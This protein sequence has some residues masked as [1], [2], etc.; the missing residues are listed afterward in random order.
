M[1]LQKKIKYALVGSVAFLAV[2][3]FAAAVP[4]SDDFYFQPEWTRSV[5]S[6]PPIG[7]S[8]AN[9]GNLRAFM[10]GNDFGFFSPDGDVFRGNSGGMRFSAGGDAWCVYAEDA[11]NTEVYGTD[12]SRKMTVSGAGFVRITENGTYLFH[13]GGGAVS[14]YADDGALIW[15]RD[16]AAPITAFSD[17]AAGT[18]IGYGNGLLLAVD[19]EGR[20]LFSFYPGGS[21]YQVVLG[22]ALSESGAFAVCV[23]GVSP[24]RVILIEIENRQHRITAH[25][26]LEGELRRQAFAGFSESGNRAFFETAAGLGIIDTQARSFS[27]VAVEGRIVSVAEYPGTGFFAVLANTRPGSHLLSLVQNPGVKTAA[28]SFDCQDAF[29]LFADGGLCLGADGSISKISLRTAK[30]RSR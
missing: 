23:S 28:L 3:L 1:T 6:A 8:S 12:G 11:R 2:Y 21:D 15:T 27:E 30:D 24:Q 17:S 7:E 13:P 18:I 10:L 16:E 20:N 9:A 29:L 22:A 4:L 5:T 25:R 19:A 14:R 26:N